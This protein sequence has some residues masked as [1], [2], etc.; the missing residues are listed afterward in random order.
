MSFSYTQQ[1][2][3][4]NLFI[5]EYA[6]IFVRLFPIKQAEIS[7]QADCVVPNV[8]RMAFGFV[9]NIFNI[10]QAPLPR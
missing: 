9:L 3:S 1:S 4:I 5:A 6:F 2:S 10:L 7:K 8:G